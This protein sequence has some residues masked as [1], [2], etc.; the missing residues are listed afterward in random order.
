V[1][2]LVTVVAAALINS[3]GEILIAQRPAHKHMGGLWEF[4]GGK[5]EVGES[6]E[7]ALVRELHEELGIEVALKALAPLTFVSHGYETFH[8]LM[9]CYTLRT[10][11]GNPTSTEHTA[12]AWVS[13][14][15]LT[16]YPMP[17]ADIPLIAALQSFAFKAV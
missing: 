12:L 16:D 1:T 4:P 6:P 10:W 7:A 9:L 3:A 8:L 14:D 17:P 2:K 15:K 13:P 5:I 11:S